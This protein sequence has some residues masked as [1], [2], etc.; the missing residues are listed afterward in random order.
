VNLYK[1]CAC[2]NPNKCRH[3]FWFRFRLDRRHVRESTK[4][5]NRQLAGRVAEKRHLEIVAAGHGFKRI[6]PVLLSKHIEAYVT[7][8]AKANRTSYKDAA[9]LARLVESMGDRALGDVSAFHVER[10]KR[11]RAD[12]V[13]KATVNRELNIVRGC[14]S[15]AVEWGHLGISP[16]RAVSRTASITSDSVSARRLKFTPSSPGRLPISRSSPG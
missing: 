6:K 1:R 12:A 8:T 7:H 10:W 16:L 2:A 14:F 15:R 13:E 3:P 11:E 5:A 9:V 4:T